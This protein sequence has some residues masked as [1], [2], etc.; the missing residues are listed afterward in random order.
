MLRTFALLTVAVVLAGTGAVRVGLAASLRGT[1]KLP[2]SF[3]DRPAFSAPGFWMLP[4]DVIEIRPPLVDPRMTMV[5]VLEGSGLPI[6]PGVKPEVTISDARLTPP[7]LPVQANQPITFSNKDA[8]VHNLEPVGEKFMPS[9]RL[10]TNTA[11]KGSIAKPGAYRLQCSVV[12]HVVG[13]ILVV[14]APQFT[15]PDANGAFA[16]GEIPNGSYTLRIWYSGKWVHSQPVAVKGKSR[17]EILLRA[18]AGKDAAKDAG[19]D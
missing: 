8:S 4:N 16:F 3:R 12:P 14:D 18:D 13:T 9:M 2:K 17:V 6:K 10:L 1:V 15:L 19:K 11:K 5:V 7:V